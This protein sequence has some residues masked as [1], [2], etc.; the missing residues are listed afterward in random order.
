MS[1]TILVVMSSIEEYINLRIKTLASE[2]FQGLLYILRTVSLMKYFSDHEN[3]FQNLQNCNGS[4]NDWTV[5]ET[6]ELAK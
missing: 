2:Y 1:I 4:R 3:D 6:V 5:Q